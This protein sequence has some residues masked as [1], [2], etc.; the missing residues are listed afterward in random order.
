M[1]AIRPSFFAVLYVK[2]EA[3][4]VFTLGFILGLLAVIIY[5]IVYFVIYVYMHLLNKIWIWI[6]DPWNYNQ[7]ISTLDPFEK[8]K[9]QLKTVAWIEALGNAGHPRSFEHIR[10][11]TNTSTT[12]GLLKRAGLHA[13]RHYHHQAVWKSYSSLVF[14]LTLLAW[15]N[16]T[17]FS[18]VFNL[19][20]ATCGTRFVVI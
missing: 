14:P 2:G 9:H 10:S 7:H 20:R 15:A 4:Q 16:F 8:D 3:S 5:L 17:R 12:Q 18:P 11:F 19:C 1:Y 13:M 6:A